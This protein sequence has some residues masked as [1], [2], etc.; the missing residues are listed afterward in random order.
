VI[1]PNAVSEELE[2]AAI[3]RDG[4]YTLMWFPWSALLGGMRGLSELRAAE[5]IGI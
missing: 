2:A 4:D 1:S 3:R 5:I